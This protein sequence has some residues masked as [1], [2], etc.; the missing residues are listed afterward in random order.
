MAG[1]SFAEVLDDALARARATAARTA[2]WATPEG[3]EGAD[4]FLFTKPFGAGA[5]WTRAYP[6]AAGTRDRGV[7]QDAGMP[8]RAQPAPDAHALPGPPPA[9]AAVPPPRVL[10]SEERQALTDLLALGAG[11]TEAFTATDLRRE[12]RRLAFALHPDRHAQASPAERLRL[13][14][15]FA[16]A[17]AAY[18]RLL[19]VVHPRH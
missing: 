6:R 10:T 11:L 12:Y 16:R 5:A 3:R 4:P 17:T 15:A 14:E 1:P 18:R 13:G 19:D 7:T 9:S 8:P 2:A